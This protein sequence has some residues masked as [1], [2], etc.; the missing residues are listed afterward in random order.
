MARKKSKF[1]DDCGRYEKIRKHSF[2]HKKQ[3]SAPPSFVVEQSEWKQIEKPEDF[4]ARVVEV[5]K[6]Y[7][8]VCRE[9]QSS[10]KIDSKDIWLAHMARKHIHSK[11]EERNFITVGDKVLCRPGMAG[12]APEV[13]E[14]LPSCSIECRSPRSTKLSRTDPLLPEREHVIAANLD[15]LVIVASFVTPEVK[16]RFIDRYLVM[17]ER[18]AIKPVLVLTKQDLFKQE[19]SEF[20]AQT[21]EFIK[22]YTDLGYTIHLLRADQPSKQDRALAKKIFSEKV[23]V[24]TGHSGVGKSSLVNILKPELE[25]AV[26]EEALFRKGRHTTSFSSMI[27]LGVGGF[28]I[29][30]PGIRSLTLPEM[31]HHELSVCFRDFEPYLGQ[32]K[33]R[34]C[35]HRQEPGCAILEAIENH[36]IH[37]SRYQ[38]Y[39]SLLEN[40]STR[41]GRE[42][43]L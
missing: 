37:P 16:W 11:R 5:H 32:C 17:A 26:E 19:S 13:S 24:V 3:K 18:D 36:K 7:A 40:I 2:K 4:S 29:D 42:G 30:T 1:G 39:V 41:E 34:E 6:R 8:F 9:H 21:H 22:L 35:R 43:T 38:T 25:Q 20:Q 15:Q 33:Y 27:R 31:D 28:I 23:S 10:G 12:T 14:D